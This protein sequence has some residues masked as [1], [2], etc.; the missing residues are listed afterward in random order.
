MYYYVYMY[1]LLC[2]CGFYARHTLE[3]VHKNSKITIK[4]YMYVYVKALSMAF[5]EENM[6]INI[7]Y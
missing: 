5:I 7:I 3:Q 2:L 1:V 4:I 6:S